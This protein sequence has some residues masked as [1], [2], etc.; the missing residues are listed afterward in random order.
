M[1][2]IQ[3]TIEMSVQEVQKYKR[4][5]LLM[6]N[7]YHNRLMSAIVERQPQHCEYLPDIDGIGIS[8]ALNEH[9]L[10]SGGGVSNGLVNQQPFTSMRRGNS[11]ET[12]VAD[13]D[14]AADQLLSMI[15]VVEEEAADALILKNE[16]LRLK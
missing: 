16:E 7:N 2:K 8:S 10:T 3:K 9:S 12:I 15:S 6:S 14:E 13:D 1:E 4:D 5:V 11:E